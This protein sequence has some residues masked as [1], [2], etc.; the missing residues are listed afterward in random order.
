MWLNAFGEAKFSGR[1]TITVAF[2]VCVTDEYQAGDQQ[3]QVSVNKKLNYDCVRIHRI[4]WKPDTSHHAANDN[5]YSD[6]RTVFFYE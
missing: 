5:T 3:L 4:I 2:N 6:G 1:L